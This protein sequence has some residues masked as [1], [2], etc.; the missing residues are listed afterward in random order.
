MKEKIVRYLWGMIARFLNLFVPV[1]PKHW[2]FGSDFGQ[3]YREGSKYLLEYMQKEHPEYVCTFIAQ[4]KQLVSDLKRQGIPA[5]YNYSFDGIFKILRADCV[6]TAQFI[7][8]IY[9]TF[10]K[11]DR[12]FFYVVH[13][14][15]FKYAA[16]M[17]PEDYFD[18]TESKFLKKI[19]HLKTR[20]G[21]FFTLGY[22][23]DDV[24]F[25]S[26]TSEFTAGFMQQEHKKSEVKILGMPR[27]DALFDDDRMKKER[28]IEGV[29]NKFV[30]TYMPTHR[31]YGKGLVSPIPFR[32]NAIVQKWLR[33]NNIVF[34]VKQHLN[35]IH[36]VQETKSD[37]VIIDIT[38]NYYDPMT[39]IYHSDVLI[40]DYSSVWMDY[41][42]LK[43]PLIFYFYDNFE[44]E[45][46]GCY[47]NLR[48]EF[49]NNYCESEE[50]LFEMI[51]K[52]YSDK[53]SLI[54]SE[55]EI[56]KFHKYIDNNSCKR[57]YQAIAKLKYGEE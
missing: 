36:L 12:Y 18:K 26:A 49:P 25:V 9:F 46:V 28:W 29:E 31:K 5:A 52:A 42:L 34:I 13:G 2:I 48:D 24:T 57:Y 17:L 30:I 40:T 32:N 38:K 35:M 16:D 4:N 3:T 33:D 6:F 8:D 20:L 43:R 55:S 41:L 44:T 1:K 45:D 51:Q 56:H 15:P 22:T 27:N 53:V 11:K 19:R 47:Y 14:Q 7:N 21:S 23:I 10:K 37:D 50:K 39:V 54:P